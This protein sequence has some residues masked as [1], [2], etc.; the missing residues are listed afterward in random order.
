[1]TKHIL[2]PLR[3]RFE[4]SYIP[5]PNSGCFLW[6]KAT[7]GVYGHGVMGRG[8]RGT[9]LILAH[10]AAWELYR[11]PIPP[12]LLVCHRCDVPCCVNPDHLFLGTYA[13]NNRDMVTK[14]RHPQFGMTHCKRGHP[15][16]YQG[17]AQQICRTCGK[18]Y[19]LAREMRLK[20]Q[21]ISP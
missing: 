7:T 3:D 2:T 14:G 1:M 10:R 11:G 12:G 19:R 8:R 21:E 15:F 13:D 18:A 20:Q 4:A 6:V 9:G 16:S 17:R 5:E